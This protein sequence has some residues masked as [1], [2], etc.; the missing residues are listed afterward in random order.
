MNCQIN[1]EWAVGLHGYQNSPPPGSTFAT[2]HAAVTSLFSRIGVKATHMG[3]DGDGYSGKFF[4]AT[5]ATARRLMDSDF[6]DITGLSFAVNPKDSRAP[7]YDR[8][9]YTSLDWSFSTELTLC[10]TVNEGLEP[11]L[12][13]VFESTITDMLKTAAW[14]FGYAFR[15]NVDRRPDLHVLGADSGRLDKAESRA[16]G[17]WYASKPTD[18]I[19][20]IRNIYPVTIMNESQRTLNVNGNTVTQILNNTPGASWN[21]IGALVI[22]RIPED[23]LQRLRASLGAGGALII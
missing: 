4:K 18:R 17:K 16:L 14:S 2:F 22:W 3:A 11:F 8:L 13:P 9:I 1:T 19:H 20:K 15:D 5:S 6:K 23:Q 10:I 21:Q 12:G 7:A